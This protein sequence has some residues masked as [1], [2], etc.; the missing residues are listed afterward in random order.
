MSSNLIPVQYSNSADEAPVARVL[1]SVF[2]SAGQ[3][4]PTS[5]LLDGSDHGFAEEWAEPGHVTI[6]GERREARLMYLFAADEV[7]DDPEHYPW[8]AD[9]VARIVLSA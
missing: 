7:A 2:S 5:R 9:H 1:F 6:A 4:E 3:A 8:D